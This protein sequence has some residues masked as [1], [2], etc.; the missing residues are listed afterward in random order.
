MNTKFLFYKILLFFIFYSSLSFSQKTTKQTVDSVLNTL[1]SKKFKEQ[2][3]A[4]FYLN[5]IISKNRKEAEYLFEYVLSKDS[6]E[7]SKAI[8]NL[9]YS[10][11]L[12][13][14]GLTDESIALKLE[15]LDIVEQLGDKALIMEYHLSLGSSYQFQNKIDKALYHLNLGQVIAEE[16]AHND[17]LWNFYYQ[18]GLI[19]GVLGDSEGHTTYFKKMWDLCKNYGNNPT[20]RFI[21]YILIDYFSQINEPILLSEITESLAK[22][23]EEADPNTPAGHLPI[24]SI[25]DKKTDPSNIP[26]L[27]ESIRISDSLNS[28]NSLCYSTI[29]L[30]NTYSKMNKPELAIPYL[31]NA[32]DKLEQ[33]NKPQVTLDIL[34]TLANTASEANNYKVAYSYKSKEYALRDSLNSNKMQKNIAELQVQFDTEKK[35]RKILEQTLIIEK[36]ERQ[37]NQFIIGIITLGL[38]LFMGFIFFKK[39]LKYIQ[40]I[41]AQKEEIQAQEITELRQ[42]NKLLALN[43]MI[44]GQ[45]VERL[46]IAKDLHDSLGGLLSTVKAHFTTIQREIIQLEKLNITKKTNSLIDEACIEVRRISHNMMPHALSISGL[47]GALE[48][49]AENLREDGFQTNLEISNLPEKIENTKEVM[50]YRLLQEIISNI[51]KHA[52]A[53]S[54]LIQLLGFQNEINIIIEDDGKGFDYEKAIEKGGLGLKSIN[55]RVHYLDGMIHW[56]TMPNQGTSISI[57]IP[58]K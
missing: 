55:S 26:L 10:K 15:G 40:T 3:D 20:T 25:F 58:S 21:H 18:K 56:D 23:Y 36:D 2:K 42:T 51:R 8:I 11:S 50:I 49:I 53:K 38:L 12:S 35:E 54:I 44:E 4:Y 34:S 16:P 41:T 5:N 37:R 24:K 17:F 13:Q 43:S 28:I 22:Y 32:F 33:V 29:A 30:A 9:Q 7:L 57:N 6:S 46:R 27:K 52:E 1:K 47:Q 48:D 14:K 31:K 45:E 39:R 19:Q